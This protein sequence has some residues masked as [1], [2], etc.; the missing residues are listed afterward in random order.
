MADMLTEFQ[1]FPHDARRL[2]QVALRETLTYPCQ[3]PRCSAG[4]GYQGISLSFDDVVPP[5]T[6][7]DLQMS[8]SV[9]ESA[10]EFLYFPEP[11]DLLN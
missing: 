1:R 5:L 9:D 6:Q 11:G 2:R 7:C 10:S 8:A 4:T 3:I